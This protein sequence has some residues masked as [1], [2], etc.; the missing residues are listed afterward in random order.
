MPKRSK[1]PGPSQSTS[2]RLGET[3]STAKRA[4][5]SAYERPAATV[6]RRTLLAVA[7]G[8]FLAWLAFLIV[9]AVQG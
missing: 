1:R 6:W 8:A 5:P 2:P 4:P 9:L 3:E 7:A